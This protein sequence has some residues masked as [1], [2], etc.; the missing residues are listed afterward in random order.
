MKT[1]LQLFQNHQIIKIYL[2]SININKHAHAPKPHGYK[3]LLIK[4]SHPRLR[5]LET[6]KRNRGIHK[7]TDQHAQMHMQ[8]KNGTPHVLKDVFH[9][10]SYNFSLFIF[11]LLQFSSPMS[12]GTIKQLIP[13]FNTDRTNLSLTFTDT[14]EFFLSLTCKTNMIHRHLL[15]KRIITLITPINATQDTDP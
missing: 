9:P 13:V 11:T 15:N 5:N 10:P 3:H 1:M 7:Q 4:N 2:A 6:E 8:H 14:Y 12:L